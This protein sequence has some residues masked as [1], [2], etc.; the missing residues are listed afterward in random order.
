[1]QGHFLKILPL[2]KRLE[3]QDWKKDFVAYTINKI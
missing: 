2:K 1:M 3:F